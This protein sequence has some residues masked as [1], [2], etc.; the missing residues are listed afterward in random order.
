MGWI[1]RL[2]ELWDR[3]RALCVCATAILLGAWAFAHRWLPEGFGAEAFQRTSQIPI[4]GPVSWNARL[5]FIAREKEQYLGPVPADADAGHLYDPDALDYTS[6]SGAKASVTYSGFGRH[7]V[8]RDA[9][10]SPILAIAD[11]Q[12]HRFATGTEDGSIIIW[13]LVIG[14]L[15]DK[16][17][18][19]AT[20]HTEYPVTALALNGNATRLASRRRTGAIRSWDLS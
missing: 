11:P 7:E 20:V 3:R 1:D 17:N 4:V 10:N 6:F 12:G 9:G 8:R 14:C 15:E 13:Q 16:L 18:A 19:V 5:R 2:A